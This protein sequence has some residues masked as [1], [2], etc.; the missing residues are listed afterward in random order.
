MAAIPDGHGDFIHAWTAASGRITVARPAPG[1]PLI[2]TSAQTSQFAPALGTL[3]G[4]IYLAWTQ[5]DGHL[6][7]GSLDPTGKLADPIEQV[8][9]ITELSLAGPALINRPGQTERLAILWTGVDGT[10]ALNA[11]VVYFR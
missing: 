8:T 9:Q 11:A 6:A 7:I 2:Y 1:Q 5:P 4:D 3:A 10:G